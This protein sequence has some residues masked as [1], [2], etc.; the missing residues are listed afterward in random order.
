MYP[1]CCPKA[2]GIGSSPRPRKHKGHRAKGWMGR[3]WMDRY[4]NNSD[5]PGCT[6]KL[7]KRHHRAL[8]SFMWLSS[9]WCKQTVLTSANINYFSW[10][11]LL[12]DLVLKTCWWTSN[13]SL[14]VCKALLLRCPIHKIVLWMPWA[15]TWVSMFSPCLHGFSPGTLASSH[16]GMHLG[17]GRIGNSQL[18]LYL[19][20]AG[21]GCL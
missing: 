6:V 1:A 7:C 19:N 10:M 2:D 16:K 20:V 21:N 3:G 9:H 4:S 17:D 15:F 18:P 14:Q 12:L 11:C 13:G 5:K 8:C